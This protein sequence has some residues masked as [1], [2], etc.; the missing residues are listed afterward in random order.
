MLC[1]A[2]RLF[3]WPKLL[4][5]KASWGRLLLRGACPDLST[6]GIASY[7]HPLLLLYVLCY[8]R[9]RSLPEFAAR[10]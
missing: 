8:Q 2:G 10:I 3:V 6:S 4:L 5:G 1:G 9:S 7:L